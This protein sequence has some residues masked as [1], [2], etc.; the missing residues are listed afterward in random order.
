MLR[1]SGGMSRYV[2]PDWTGARVFF[3]LCLAA[4]GSDL[5][6]R[7]IAA[8]RRAVDQTQKERPFGIEAWVV[9]P[10]HLHCVWQMPV[11]DRA[12]GVRWHLIKGRFAHGLEA[13]PRSRSKIRKAEKGIW[14]RRYWEHHIR[15]EADFQ[16][17]LLYCWANPVK[18]GFV[19]RAVDWPHSSIHRDIRL[20]LVAPE[21]GG[22]VAD[23]GFGE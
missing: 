15:D 9:L 6:L 18:H 1:H 17:H 19:R 10:D 3:T 16:A 20:G 8:L 23:G 11:G 4:R 14:Q 5:L 12:Y 21:W 2:R 22:S 13:Q 7:E